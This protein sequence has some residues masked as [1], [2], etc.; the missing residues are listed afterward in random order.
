[1]KLWRILFPLMFSVIMVTSA[2]SQVLREEQMTP[3]SEIAK[4]AIQA[5]KIPGAVILIANEGKVVYR[6]A[7]GVERTQT[8]EVTHDHRYHLRCCF[9]DEG[10]RNIHRGDAAGGDGEVESR[11]PGCQLLA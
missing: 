5:G 2:S 6:K 4:R 11:R 1:M 9:P 8:E 10:H 3:I 7:F